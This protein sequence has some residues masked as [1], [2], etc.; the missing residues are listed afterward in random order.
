MKGIKIFKPLS[1]IGSAISLA[2]QEIVKPLEGRKNVIATHWD[3]YLASGI[4]KF[5][6]SKIRNQFDIPNLDPLEDVS[7]GWTPVNESDDVEDTRFMWYESFERKEELTQAVN[8]V[9]KMLYLPK[10]AFDDVLYF[11]LYLQ[12]PTGYPL[13]DTHIIYEIIWNEDGTP[14]FTGYTPKEV[15]FLKDICAFAIRS[16]LFRELRGSTEKVM[17]QRIQWVNS[18]IDTLLSNKYRTIRPLRNVRL[19]AAIMKLLPRYKKMGKA[20]DAKRQVADAKQWMTSALIADEI[21]ISSDDDELSITSTS[22][23][24]QVERLKRKFPFL[25]EMHPNITSK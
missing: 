11:V 19:D 20:Y 9:R 13:Y 5:L 17:E 8:D 12:K 16:G 3:F 2:L 22:F 21:Y 6:A 25:S 1:P 18:R 10:N 23:R 24:K 4:L 14:D 15:R 7:T